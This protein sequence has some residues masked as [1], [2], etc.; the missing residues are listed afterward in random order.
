[1]KKKDKIDI[2]KN[3]SPAQF[4]S[5][6]TESD[7]GCV[8]ILASVF[9]AKLKWLLETTI[10]TNLVGKGADKDFYKDLFG[11]NGALGSFSARLKIAFAFRLI[12]EDQFEA[13]EALR[14]VRNKVA[15]LP[16]DFT[17][18]DTEVRKVLKRI[19]DLAAKIDHDKVR[20]L[21]G[22]TDQDEKFELV[23]AAF[24]IHLSMMIPT[25]EASVKLMQSRGINAA[26]GM[27]QALDNLRRFDKE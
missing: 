6:L 12:T 24:Q 25:M 7:R 3:A 4:R 13:M 5:F 15:H 16:F 2:F 8:L 19:T 23:V 22:V 1:M 11:L 17:L 14:Y 26:K 21:W 27:Q 18:K 20:K 10:K 9:D